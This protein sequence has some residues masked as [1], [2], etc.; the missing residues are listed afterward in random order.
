M[1]SPSVF[2]G[3]SASPGSDFLS[4]FTC[5]CCFCLRVIFV[6]TLLLIHT[7]FTFLL[8]DIESAVIK[9]HF[10]ILVTDVNRRCNVAIDY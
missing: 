9:A 6:S 4:R 10:L 8:L 5:I 2:E 7:K 1:F 3:S